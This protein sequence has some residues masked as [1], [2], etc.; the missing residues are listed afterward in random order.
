M[1][2]YTY[3]SVA[4]I[5]RD[6]DL[7][8]RLSACAQIEG[9]GDG[10]PWGWVDMRMWIFAATPGW[11]AK[12]LYA[13]DVHKTDEE[14]RPGYDE[15]VITDLDILAAVQAQIAKEQQ[16]AADLAAMQAAFE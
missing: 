11:G 1:A 15:A 9:V 14:Y 12:F 10:N 6:N 5:Q 2:D 4:A 7:R 13:L 8:L 3:N 16:D